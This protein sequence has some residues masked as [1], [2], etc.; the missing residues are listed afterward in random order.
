MSA[1]ARPCDDGRAARP[2]RD[3]LRGAGAAG[4]GISSLLLPAAAASA[5]GVFTTGQGDAD[6]AMYVDATTSSSWSA[7]AAASGSGT[8]TDL[9]GANRS[10][11]VG[12]SGQ[13]SFTTSGLGISDGTGAF[14]F[15]ATSGATTSTA[16]PEFAYGDGW[17]VAAWVRFSDL[18][19]WQNIVTQGDTVLVDGV[20]NW[21]TTNQLYFQKSSH[22]VVGTASGDIGSRKA[23][24][25]G[26][27]LERGTGERLLCFVD[28]AVIVGRWYHVVATGSA[29]GVT[30]HL[31]GGAGVPGGRGGTNRVIVH[32]LGDEAN[33]TVGGR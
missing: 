31:D 4:L 16:L 9:T 15:T 21:D 25:L 10:L 27:A 28:E 13:P 23:N 1:V 8:W 17:T 5:S 6:L 29:A 20:V 3:V 24:Q 7:E 30:V 22:D 18:T 12:G 33:L 19:G 2:R 11:A 14:P 26:I 32:E